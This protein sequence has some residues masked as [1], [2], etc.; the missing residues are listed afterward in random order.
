[1]SVPPPTLKITLR[2]SAYRWPL[3]VCLI[4]LTTGLAVAL[5]TLSGPE[6][7]DPEAARRTV[8][9]CGGGGVFAAVAAAVWALMIY[10]TR[11]VV[12]IGDEGLTLRRGM[13]KAI[14]P[15]GA[16]DAVG[17]IWPVADPALT[18]WFAPEAAPGVASV[19]KVEGRAAALFRGR[20]LP[21]GRLRAARTATT[22]SLGAPW[23][24]LDEEG[25]EVERPPADALP[26]A[27]RIVVDGMGRYHDRRGGAL[28]AVGCGRLSRRPAD[29]PRV[30]APDRGAGHRTIVLRDP[31]ARTLLV[32]RRA[33][34]L[35]GRHRIRVLGGDGRPAGLVIGGDEPSFH[36]VDGMLLGTTRRTGGHYVVTGVDGRPAGSLRTGDGADEGGMR[37]ERSPS[38]PEPLRTLLLALPMV[39]RMARQ[40]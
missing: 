21:P 13:R 20:S 4:A 36:T 33:A 7:W 39:V 6:A 23:R 8:A 32:F 16:V 29:R 34:R 10:W 24:V 25:A 1:M 17:L 26:R 15:A 3:R 22:E 35:P 27:D 30:L 18:V 38:A 28:L 5:S 19:T 31:H 11:L 12:T 40:I 2:R 14:I 37:L 9:V